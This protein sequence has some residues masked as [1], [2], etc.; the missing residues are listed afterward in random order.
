MGM[1]RRLR[2]R[3]I[4]VKVVKNVR[5][6]DRFCERMKRIYYLSTTPE[7]NKS[8]LRNTHDEL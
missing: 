8:L 7:E 2:A 4:A 3:M 5:I 1:M 6:L